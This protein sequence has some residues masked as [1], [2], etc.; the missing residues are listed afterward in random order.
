MSCSSM[1]FKNLQKTDAGP[2][3]R[4]GS[5]KPQGIASFLY[6]AAQWRSRLTYASAVR[7]RGA[8][9]SSKIALRRR[10]NHQFVLDLLEGGPIQCKTIDY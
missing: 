9:R 5:A 1:T 4:A 10:R 8:D 3:L 6:S 2:L 7:G